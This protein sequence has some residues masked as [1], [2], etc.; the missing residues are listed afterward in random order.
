MSVDLCP[1][2]KEVHYKHEGLVNQMDDSPGPSI[3]KALTEVVLQHS[4]INR[5]IQM[6]QP[7]SLTVGI[8]GKPIVHRKLE[9]SDRRLTLGMPP[10]SSAILRVNAL[11]M[12]MR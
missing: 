12:D 3:G 7:G 1:R 11:I 9:C 5:I 6:S 2:S 4:I 10:N 8:T